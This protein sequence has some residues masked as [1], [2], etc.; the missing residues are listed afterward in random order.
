MLCPEGYSRSARAA[1]E[2]VALGQEVAIGL[3]VLGA[4]H[5]NA[6]ALEALQAML[7]HRPIDFLQHVETHGDL[8]VRRHADDVRVE[9]GVVYQDVRRSATAVRRDLRSRSLFEARAFDELVVAGRI[10][11]EKRIPSLRRRRQGR[12]SARGTVS[13]R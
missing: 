11:A 3:E 7:E 13:K 12:G 1:E 5:V 8:E 4:R 6:P 9:R 10:S 2:G